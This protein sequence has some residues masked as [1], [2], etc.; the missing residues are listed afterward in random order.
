RRGGSIL[1]THLH[2]FLAGIPGMARLG[3]WLPCGEC[4]T[5]CIFQRA[6][7]ARL[8]AASC[9]GRLAGR[10]SL[11]LTSRA[12]RVPSLA[13]G[14]Q[15]RCRRGLLLAGAARLVAVSPLPARSRAALV[16]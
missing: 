4:A 16:A 12:G 3:G 9:A 5:A 13:D 10:R 8:T 7:L 1:S 14:T 2:K 11:W 15:E 6:L